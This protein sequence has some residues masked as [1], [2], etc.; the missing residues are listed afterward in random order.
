MLKYLSVK[1]NVNYIEAGWTTK[2]LVDGYKFKLSKQG[3]S[4]V[5]GILTATVPLSIV[6]V[7]SSFTL[8]K[9]PGY[10]YEYLKGS[11]LAKLRSII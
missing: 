6:T 2:S 3:D 1:P 9:G 10:L 7:F 5:I 4:I 11:R 8:I